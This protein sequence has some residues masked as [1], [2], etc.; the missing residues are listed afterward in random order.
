MLEESTEELVRHLQNP[1]GWWRDTAQK[2]ILLRSDRKK[3]IP[4]LEGLFRFTQSPLPRMH[5]LWTLDGMDALTPQIKKEALSDRSP[6]LRRAMVQI[7]ESAL[8]DQLD[9]LALLE[10]ERDSR[11]AEQLVFTLGTIDDPKAE[12][13]IQS[14][15]STHLADKGVMLATTVS[16]WGKKDLPLVEQ[17]KSSKAF[18]KL[19]QS[20]R[21]SVNM[22]WDKALSSWDRGMKFDKDFDVSH[23]KMIQTGEQLY[24]QHCTS[25]HG[26]DGLGVQ[27]PGTNQYLAPSLVDSK[28]VHGDPEQLL[29]LFF[30]GLMGPID[31][32]TYQAGYMAPAKTFGIEREDRLADLVTYLRYAWGK[33]GTRIDKSTVSN[34]RR[35][36]DK[37]TVP[38]TDDELKS[39][40]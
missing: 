29:P 22:E 16:L 9:L 8:P 36:H 1:I 13:M 10:K 30:H 7:I 12:E 18:A 6:V 17:L 31:G 23:R 24:F 4:L 33:K 27:I 11:V 21:A 28:R 39:L 32:K 40:R 37:R 19:P 38:W 35:K 14:L 20:K 3:T 2:L 25:C 5:A 15:A 34:I 26:A